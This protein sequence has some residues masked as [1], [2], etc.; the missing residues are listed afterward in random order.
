MCW[1]QYVSI[2][3]F[4]FGIFGLLFIFFNNTYSDYK[5]DFFK[6]P[7]AYLFMLSFVFMQLFEFILWRNLDPF[8]TG[9]K[10]DNVRFCSV[11]YSGTPGVN[12][13]TSILGFLLLSIQPVASLLLLNNIQLRNKLLLAYS[14]PAFMFVVYNVLVANI[15]TVLSPSGHLAWKWTFYKNRLLSWFIIPFY[16]FFLFF[17]LLYNKYYESLFSLLLFFIFIYYFGKDGSSGSIWCLSVNLIILYF[18]LQILI[19][20]PYKELIGKM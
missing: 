11:G 10:S 13:F 12:N 16:L 3:T 17:S 19:V 14:I 9:F 15:H 6:N 4:V 8:P 20:M 18:L 7:Y 1:N 5:L 2:N